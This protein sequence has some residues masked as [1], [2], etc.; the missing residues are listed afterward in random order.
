MELKP[1]ERLKYSV[2]RDY[3]NGKI[4]RK[5]ASVKLN[6][7][8]STISV[9][10]SGY[11]TEGKSFFK[12][13]SAG[14]LPVNKVLPEV[15]DN[16]VQCYKTQFLGFN[17]THF[18]DSIEESGKL[19]E[20]TYGECLTPRTVARLLVRNG[21]VSPQAN[22]KR[23]KDNNHPLRPR[24]LGFGELVQMDA[25][26]HDWLSIGHDIALHLAIDDSDSSILAAHFMKT[27]TLTGYFKIFHQILL[28]YGIPD[29]FYTD[30]R[31]V[32][33]RSSMGKGKNN[34]KPTQFERACLDLGV[35]IVSTSVAQAKGRVERSF[36]T[37][38]DRLINELKKAGIKTINEAN[39]FLLDYI[40]RH[41]EKFALRP[42]TDHQELS[43][44]PSPSNTDLNRIL[45]IRKLHK[46]LNGNIISFGNKQYYLTKDNGERLILP[47][48]TPIEIIKAFD[49]T[50]LAHYNNRYF[51]L[52]FFT[53]GRCSAH[54][55]PD[56]HPWKQNYG[57]KLSRK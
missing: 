21:I 24:R 6:L 30:R 43:F 35:E 45:S 55:P 4:K 17:F 54:K 18:Y 11:L 27:E 46:V 16:V 8:P 26:I 49:E 14:S 15:E 52:E 38:Q 22:K 5:Q 56:S 42:S 37:H 13:K 1:S 2:I 44:R 28:D 31:I 57:Q 29:T 48:D 36:R 9:L 7:T 3:V 47:V 25:S 32:F 10:K 51:Q 33:D 19:Y 20:L 53:D 12:H 41:N 34:S 40:R 23:V 50:L 39:V